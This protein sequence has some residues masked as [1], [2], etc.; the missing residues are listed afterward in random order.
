MCQV[1][2]DFDEINLALSNIPHQIIVYENLITYKPIELINALNNII[3]FSYPGQEGHWTVL[4]MYP[5]DKHMVFFDPYGLRPDDE[6]PYL[7]NP[8]HVIIKHKW[9]SKVIIPYFEQ[10]G[11]MLD[12]NHHNIQ[13]YF[14]STARSECSKE[15]AENLCGELVVLRIIYH[16]LDNDTFAHMIKQYRPIQIVEIISDLINENR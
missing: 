6:W 14:D 1:A 16:H 15:M 11:W 7:I 4:M 3:F 13:G 9:L 10:N 2:M 12:V 5:D 8:N